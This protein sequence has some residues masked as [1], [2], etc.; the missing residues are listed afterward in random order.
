MTTEELL[1]LATVLEIPRPGHALPLQLRR[2]YGYADRWAICD[3]EGRRWHREYGWV[4]QDDG[5]RYEAERNA[6]RYTLAEAVPIARMLADGRQPECPPGVNS[7]FD[8]CPGN[9]TE[10]VDDIDPTD[11]DVIESHRLA[12]SF[13]LGLGTG[14]PWEAIRDRATELHGAA[15][16]R[17]Q[18]AGRSDVGTEFVRQVDQ[19]DQAG[20]DAF[21]ADLAETEDGIDQMMAEGE[22]VQDECTNCKGSGLDPRSNGEFVCPDCASGEGPHKHVWVTALDG[23]NQPARNETGNT[24]THCGVCGIPR[25]PADV[26]TLPQWLY[27]RFACPGQPAARIAWDLLDDNI[28]SY[29]KHTADAVRRAVA[30]D[31]FK[32]PS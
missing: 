1:A 21:E 30:R 3:R 15:E 31:G 23:D 2:S 20:L 22:P 5:S 25:D 9:C 26:D 24:W 32:E 16:A 19:P 8:P 13:A 7:I 27:Q 6:S 29:W 4:M 28:R 11:E 12:L 14:A 10:P 17:Q 18:E